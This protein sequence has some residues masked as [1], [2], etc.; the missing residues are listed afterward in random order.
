MP[1]QYARSLTSQQGSS[2]T[3]RHLGFTLAFIAGAAN[4]GAYLA[5]QIYTSHMT[6]I[7]SSLADH[8]VLGE[9]TLALG[10]MG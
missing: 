7:V 2:R 1:I 8:L 3:I 5:V 9:F 4:A 10:A 6:G